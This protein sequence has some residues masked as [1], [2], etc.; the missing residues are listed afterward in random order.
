MEFGAKL[1]A[2]LKLP[3]PH[4]LGMADCDALGSRKVTPFQGGLMWED[5]EERVRAEFP[6]R[7]FLNEVVAKWI[8]FRYSIAERSFRALRYRWLPWHRYHK[9]DLSNVDTLWPYEYD[10]PPVP[11]RIMWLAGWKALRLYIEQGKPLDPAAKDYPEG[12]RT[13]QWYLDDKARYDEVIALYR[14]WMVERPAEHAKNNELHLAIEVAADV[15]DEAQ[16]EALTRTWLDHS[17]AVELREG[18]MFQRLAKLQ[19]F[20]HR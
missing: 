12:Y 9:L 11:S 13:T 18:E 10:F 8:S 2:R 20:L 3:G 14:Y 15:R 6:V 16:Y 19:P 17:H 4:A 7:Y 5:W 1:L